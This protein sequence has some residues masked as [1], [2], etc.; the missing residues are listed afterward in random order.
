[1][2]LAVPRDAPWYARTFDRTWLKAHPHRGEEEAERRAPDVVRLLG[3]GVGD[4]LLDVGC[5]AG[6]YARAFARRGIRVTG[7]DLSAELLDEGRQKGLLLPNAPSY[8][9]W[10]MRR[11]P[12]RLCFE[13]AVSLFTSIGYFDSTGDDLLV[14]QGVRQA[15]VPGGRFVLDFLNAPQVRSALVAAEDQERGSLRLRVRRRIEPGRP[16]GR[17]VKEVE[18]F[19][20]VTGDRVGSFEERVWLYERVQVDGL[21]EQAGLEPVGEPLGDVDGTPWSAS[22]PRLVRVAARR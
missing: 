2:P 12:Y 10:D 18:A 7:V 4:R 21:L 19:D 9:R 20:A 3:L 6:R 1:M 14:F 22:A 8:V 13:G 17:V 11:L 15:L 5:G 16:C